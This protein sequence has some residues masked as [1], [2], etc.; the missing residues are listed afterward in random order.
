M[1]RIANMNLR[2]VNDKIISLQVTLRQNNSQAEYGMTGVQVM[3][4]LEMAEARR[5]EL[6]DGRP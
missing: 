4:L 3:A 2:Q 5:D 1:T 6:I